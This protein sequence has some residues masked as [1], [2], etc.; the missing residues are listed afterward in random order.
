MTPKEG[1]FPP[2]FGWLKD[3]IVDQAKVTPVIG[4]I[5]VDEMK[6]KSDFYFNP[7]NGSSA[8]IVVNDI[9]QRIDLADE[10]LKLFNDGM[11]KNKKKEG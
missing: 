9:S 6:L 11:K 2:L 7:K 3:T 10:V 1:T 8:G 5:N 4:H